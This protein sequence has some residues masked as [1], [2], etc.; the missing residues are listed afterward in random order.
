MMTIAKGRCVSD[1]MAC[2]VAAGKRP[3]DASSAVMSTGRS[4]CETAWRMASWL[5]GVSCRAWR[6]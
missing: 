3:S 2:E 5:S 4:R 6:T 1:P